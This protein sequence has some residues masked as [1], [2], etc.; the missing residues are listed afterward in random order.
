MKKLLALVL[1]LLFLLSLAGCNDSPTP[2]VTAPP[3]N[4]TGE[5]QVP[6]ET[7]SGIPHGVSF[8]LPTR[9]DFLQERNNGIM[10]DEGYYYLANGNLA[11]VD[12][13]N[14]NSV[15]LCSKVGCTHENT[16]G[17]ECDANLHANGSMDLSPM[18][19]WDGHVYYTSEDYYG[20]HLYRRNADGTGKAKLATLAKEYM[21]EKQ[22]I[23]IYDALLS[24]GRLYYTL[25][26]SVD[27]EDELSDSIW[28]I[29]QF[30]VLRCVDLKT[31][32]DEE[33]MRGE[34]DCALKIIAA[35]ENVVIYSVTP[36]YTVPNYDYKTAPMQI[37]AMNTETGEK[38]VILDK[39]FQE[40]RYFVGIRDNILLFREPS[41]SG[42]Q[43]LIHYDISTGQVLQ[44]VALKNTTSCILSADYALLYDLDLSVNTMLD[45]RTGLAIPGEV[46]GLR[47]NVQNVNDKYFIVRQSF[48][49]ENVANEVAYSHLCFCP[50][51]ALE[52]GFQQED[53]VPFYPN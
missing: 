2:S 11:F 52:D 30:D 37:V 45:I 7:T 38:G 29:G 21:E 51:S 32:K 23:S 10:L 9:W 48:P 15:I 41:E 8:P 3:Q 19:Y 44:Q 49:S 24:N 35:S 20:T 17:N 46:D 12:F 50:F 22:S 39:T 42:D 5:T 53:L 16:Y 34:Q 31:G 6:Q 27:I 18:V 14:G 28:S 47:L 25:A 26:V 40:L 13:S 33:L 1:I 4:T 36:Y 43:S